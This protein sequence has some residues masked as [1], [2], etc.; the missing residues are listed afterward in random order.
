MTKDIGTPNPGKTLPPG[1]RPAL[2][3]WVRPAL[4]VLALAVAA[5]LGYPTV[6][7]W[8]ATK[9]AEKAAET[10][11]PGSFKVTDGQ[12]A[13]LS[14]SPVGTRLFR[15]QRDT[16]G[17]IAVDDD[18]TTPVFS[19]FSGRVVRLIA[20][21]GD[22]VK[23]GDPLLT[24]EASEFV[25]GQND[26]VAAQATL[27][28]ARAQL[29][30][31]ETAEKRQHD[32]YDAKGAAL[33]DWQQSQVD[34]ANARAGSKTAE[35]GL[36]AVRNR[37]R[38][39]GRSEAEIATLESAPDQLKMAAIATIAAP[40]G[41]TVI[42]R[43]VGP[44]EY[45]NSAAAGGAQIFA[46]G[47]LSTLWL[48]ANLREADASIAHL[49]DQVEV[50]VLAYPGRVFTGK[51]TYVAPTIDPATRRLAVRAEV[52]NEDGALKPE[53]FASFRVIS[54]DGSRTSPAVPDAAV[55]YEGETARLWVATAADKTIILRQIKVG[56][57][58]DGMVE[59]T[60]GVKPGETVV[61]KGALFIDRAA[62][63]D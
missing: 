56:R 23:K 1:D 14:F 42:S 50:T 51:L 35:I 39:L 31:A 28:A 13:T 34:L 5:W 17:K 32:L 37:L 27:G 61:T 15:D 2:P 20:H 59:V 18:T 11:A 41:G 49:G 24:V 4:I 54:S 44:G 53:M 57:V 26:L 12:W 30:L 8:F 58:Q 55:I 38:I 40:I 33:K 3:G 47:E 45:I 48:I 62:K 63:G 9:P 19:P 46:I 52:R 21:A 60:D 10:A 7:G 43:Q 16:D 36:A 29:V 6:K 25:Q 22:L